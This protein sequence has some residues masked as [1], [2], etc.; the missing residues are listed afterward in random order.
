MQGPVGVLLAGRGL[1]QQEARPMRARSPGLLALAAVVILL[2]APGAAAADPA[3]TF[4][5]R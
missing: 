3:F 2:H 5:P 4:S 1:S